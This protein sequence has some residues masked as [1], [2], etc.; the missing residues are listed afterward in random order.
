MATGK[1]GAENLVGSADTI[2]YSAPLSTLA[3][4]NLNMCN[5]TASSVLIRIAVL[6]GAIGTLATA[7]YIEY[8]TILSANG[9]IERTG[10]VVS[11]GNSIMVYS[12]T[13]NVS[14]TCWG[15]EDATV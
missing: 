10:I 15:F 9:V 5:R 2:L 14:A 11:N 7:D 13:S 3:T 1:L 12:D 6:D 4:V 8:D